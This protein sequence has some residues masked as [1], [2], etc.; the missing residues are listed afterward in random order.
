[1][2]AT[3]QMAVR[4]GIGTNNP[5]RMAPWGIHHASRLMRAPRSQSCEFWTMSLAIIIQPAQQGA[6]PGSPECSAWIG[7]HGTE[8]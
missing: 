2:S 6:V 3:I 8:P 4:T 5:T 1:M 7:G